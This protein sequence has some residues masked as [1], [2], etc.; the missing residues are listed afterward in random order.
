MLR[1]LFAF[2]DCV[3]CFLSKSTKLPPGNRNF[4]S[5][6]LYLCAHRIVPSHHLKLYSHSLE[7]PLLHSRRFSDLRQTSTSLQNRS[8]RSK[9]LSE[10]RD[11]EGFQKAQFLSHLNT[12]SSPQYLLY[13]FHIHCCMLQI[14]PELD[15]VCAASLIKMYSKCGSL[16]DARGVFDATSN[17][18]VV[19]WTAIITAYAKRGLAKNAVDLFNSMLDAKVTPDAISFANI[20]DACRSVDTFDVV[21]LCGRVESTGLDT[22]FDVG[23]ALLSF[24]A[25]RGN[26]TEAKKLF[27]KLS[28]H[29]RITWNIMISLYSHL[30]S[31]EEALQLYNDMRQQGLIPDA[32]TFVAVLQAF[33]GEA[34]L[35]PHVRQMHVHILAAQLASNT[36]LM[37]T[38]MST[39]GRCKSVEDALGLWQCIESKNV[40]VWSAFI[41]VLTELR[42]G[43]QALVYS[44][45]MLVEGVLPNEV[46]HTS[47]LEACTLEK[48]LTKGKQL[49][50]CLQG[51]EAFLN[52]SLVTTLLIL[53]NYCGSLDEVRRLFDMAKHRDVIL[54]TAVMSAHT[55]HN[56]GCVAA[57]LFDQMHEEGVLPNLV[58]YTNVLEACSTLLLL[59][60]VKH[61]HARIRS[62]DVAANIGLGTALVNKYGKCGCLTNVRSVFNAMLFKDRRSWTAIISAYAHNGKEKEALEIFELM[63]RQGVLPDG[64]SFQSIMS[65]CGHSG[66]LDLGI[67]LFFR[68]KDE[69]GLEPS[70]SHYDCVTDLLGR[71][72]HLN[73]AEQLLNDMPTIPSNFSWTTVL[74]ACRNNFDI[75]RGKRIVQHMCDT[76]RQS[77]APYVTLSNWLSAAAGSD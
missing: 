69:F 5:A 72:G 23:R 18:D 22:N 58:T 27:H 47:S 8:Q 26:K 37:T 31:R 73:V 55:F 3:I 48:M 39:Y 77:A 24:H 40:V 15:S 44:S 65:S 14:A 32:I 35:P 30:S 49:H 43:Q 74:A 2:D 11:V 29:N 16:E 28:K 42:L 10:V 52:A 50:A 54:W 6:G 19:V 33:C 36:I 66:L 1:K 34:S 53:Y 57:Q 38:L 61:V 51:S 56:R 60:F 7:S 67:G 17:R 71:A 45:R 9:S 20:L 70:A 64:I 12:F 75:H 21:S 76:G 59:S 13:G 41:G 68:M 25:A 46:T 4:S 63:I 62:R